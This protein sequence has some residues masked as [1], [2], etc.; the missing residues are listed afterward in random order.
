MTE[1][2]IEKILAVCKVWS[3]C[4]QISISDMW[5]VESSASVRIHMGHN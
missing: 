3:E 4:L 5:S 2:A 1:T